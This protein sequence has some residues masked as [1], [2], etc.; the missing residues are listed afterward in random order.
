VASGLGD[1][2]CFATLAAVEQAAGVDVPAR[3]A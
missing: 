1:K 2:L 3:P